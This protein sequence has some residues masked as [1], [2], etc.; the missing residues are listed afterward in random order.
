MDSFSGNTPDGLALIASNW[1]GAKHPAWYHNLKANPEAT[2]SMEGDTWH[3][4]A[5]PATPSERDEI[6]AN[7]LKFYPAWKKYEARAGERQIEAFV[8]SRN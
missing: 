1:G 8:L 7:G 2:V 3:A 4:T 6:W 5:R